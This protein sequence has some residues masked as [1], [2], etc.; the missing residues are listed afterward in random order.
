MALPP[1]APTEKIILTGS[2][3]IQEFSAF[4]LDAE[5]NAIY[6]YVD[7]PLV[8]RPKTKTNIYNTSTL[9]KPNVG[10]TLYLAEQYMATSWLFNKTVGQIFWASNYRETSL[11]TSKNVIEFIVCGKSGIYSA[12]T[13]VV[14][15]FNNTTRKVFFI[16][17]KS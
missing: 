6:G 14:I 17:P 5:G 9:D 13:R 1:L 15:D 8:E 10:T 11:V 4:N 7:M 2:Y 12:V 3:A 16:G